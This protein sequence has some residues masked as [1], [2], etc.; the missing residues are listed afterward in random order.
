[1]VQW[2]R[3]ALL[4]P[5]IWL[6]SLESKWWKERTVSY[7]LISDLYACSTFSPLHT[8]YK[9]TNIIN[10]NSLHKQMSSLQPLGGTWRRIVRD[11]HGRIQYMLVRGR[12]RE[13]ETWS[14]EFFITNTDGLSE[15]KEPPNLV[16]GFECL[17]ASNQIVLWKKMRCCQSG[18]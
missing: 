5:T 13:A 8:A 1:M 11:P 10:I 15:H 17:K 3:Y 7:K 4:G 14:L 9:Q 12:I 6:Q 16:V 2:E 18:M